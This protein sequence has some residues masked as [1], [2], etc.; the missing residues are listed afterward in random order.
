MHRTFLIF[1]L[2]I[3]G[4]ISARAAYTSIT[5]IR[6]QSGTDLKHVLDLYRPSPLS[7][8]PMPVILWVHGG[9]WLSGHKESPPQ[10][11]AI[12][13]AG[14]VLVAMNYRYST[15]APFPAQLQDV[16]SAIRFLRANAVTY[17]L[18]PSRIGV[19]GQSAGAHLAALAGVTSGLAQTTLGQ[20]LDVGDHLTF[21]SAVQACVVFATPSYLGDADPA[22]TV[23][24]SYLGGTLPG[25]LPTAQAASCVNPAY[26][27]HDPPFLIVHGLSDTTVF[28]A[29]SSNLHAALVAAGAASIHVTLPGVHHT[30]WATGEYPRALTFFQSV[31][32]TLPL[33]SWRELHGLPHDGSQDAVTTGGDG[34]ANVIKFAFNLAPTEGSLAIP[35]ARTLASPTSTDLSQLS[36]LPHFGHAGGEMVLTFLRRKASS[37]AGIGYFVQTTD[38][39]LTWTSQNLDGANSE[40]VSINTGWERVRFF[41]TPVPGVVQRFYRVSV[42]RF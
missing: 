15:T 38:D 18:D 20:E 11:D 17:H 2:L 3:S 21:S 40:V 22:D 32:P 7:A 39:F 29:A 28:P 14:Y 42:Q 41:Q 5:N 4:T 13:Q 8:T 12:T 24:S 34:L 27:G 19:W 25:A 10:I 31:M 30:P 26:L 1:M 9:G 35:N 36:G 6:Y 37:G 33:A 16:K 23:V